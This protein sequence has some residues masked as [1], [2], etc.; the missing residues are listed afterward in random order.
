MACSCDTEDKR[1]AGTGG[2]GQNLAVFRNRDDHQV[3]PRITAASVV[4]PVVGS[5][6]PS[7]TGQRRTLAQGSRS[8]PAQAWIAP[9]LRILGIYL[10]VRIALVLTDVLVA[11]L[12]YGANLSGPLHSWDSNWYLVVAAHGYP[13]VA[14][15]FGGELT[16]GAG[17]FLPVFPAIIR[18]FSFLGLSGVGAALVVSV[19]AGAVATLLVGR[20]GV[21]AVNQE[22]GWKAAVIFALFPG[23]GIAWGLFYCECVGLALT[24]GSLL[25]MLRERWIW[26]GVLGALATATS[27]LALPLVLGAAAPAIHGLRNRQ[28]PGALATVALVPLGFVGF[29][30]FLEARYRDLLFWWHLQHQAW[31]ASVDFGRSLLGLLAHPGT[32]GYQGPGWLELIGVCAVAA[33]LLALWRARLPAC[34]NAYCVGVVLLLFVSNSLGFKP[35]LLTWAFPALVAVA[36]VVRPRALAAIIG[37]FAAL[38]PVVFLIYT[39]FGNTMAQP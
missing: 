12:S 36:K 9:S 20:L 1:R 37:A 10:V 8:G 4:S 6:D 24:A 2:T 28:L 35:R 3:D 38:V 33:G 25:L 39:M 18:A 11:H 32:M 30:V 5:P 7:S 31:G 22:V 17:V 14:A 19:L 16:Y 23:M 21:V 26:A 34:L 15:K 13:S 27:P 29:L